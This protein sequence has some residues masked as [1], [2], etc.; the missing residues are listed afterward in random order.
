MRFGIPSVFFSVV[1]TSV[2]PTLFAQ[3]IDVQHDYGLYRLEIGQVRIYLPDDFRYGDTILLTS[4]ASLR[5]GFLTINGTIP[6]LIADGAWTYKV[7]A[8]SLIVRLGS[9]EVRLEPDNSRTDQ[10]IP[11]IVFNGNPLQLYANRLTQNDWFSIRADS[12][13]E[14][15]RLPPLAATERKVVVR[16]AALGAT[17]LLTPFGEYYTRSIDSSE[18]IVDNGSTLRIVISGVEDLRKPIQLTLLT[19]PRIPIEN[20]PVET[21]TITPVLVDRASGKA[22]LVRRI[23][24]DLVAPTLDRI[25]VRIYPGAIRTPDMQ[26]AIVYAQARAARVE[27]EHRAAIVRHAEETIRV[28]SSR[29]EFPIEREAQFR[30]LADVRNTTPLIESFEQQTQSDEQADLLRK[31]LLDHYC[32]NLRDLKHAGRRAEVKQPSR[33]FG[34]AFVPPSPQP[35]TITVNDVQQNG[36]ANFLKSFFSGNTAAR[37]GY[38]MV[39][40]DPK[41]A[42]VNV[43]NR[44]F[45]LTERTIVLSVG[46]YSVDM[47]YSGARL[48]CPN[49]ELRISVNMSQP[50]VCKAQNVRK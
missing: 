45:G 25:N 4:T 15:R 47:T 8:N 43:N 33:I 11:D 30:I 34:F 21:L 40:S 10:S 50:F 28:W 36:F 41:G 7:A 48:A 39:D 18:D 9:E 29:S 27:E 35:V 17:R 5:V 31:S 46:T 23:G 12:L 38:L 6:T 14:V 26:E 42:T 2:C 49:Q 24:R 3:S 16:V 32:Y 44:W 22:V 19:D 1:L 13:G 37:V 20:G